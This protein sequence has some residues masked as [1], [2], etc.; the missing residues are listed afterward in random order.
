MNNTTGFRQELLADDD[1]NG[2]D[3]DNFHYTFL[4][5]RGDAKIYPFVF[6]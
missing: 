3:D 6:I 5:Y 1:N 4:T 2:D